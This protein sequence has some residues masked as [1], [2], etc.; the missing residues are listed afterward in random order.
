MCQGRPARRTDNGGANATTAIFLRRVRQKK[1]AIFT[2]LALAAAGGS[3]VGKRIRRWL[4]SYTVQQVILSEIIMALIVSEESQLSNLNK[5][6]ILIVDSQCNAGHCPLDLEKIEAEEKFYLYLF[7]FTIF[8][9]RYHT[10]AYRLWKFLQPA[11]HGR[12]DSPTEASNRGRRN[13]RPTT[14]RRAGALNAS[15][16]SRGG[17]VK[18]T[19]NGF[20]HATADV[21]A[22]G[23][24]SINDIENGQFRLSVS[25][26]PIINGHDRIL[27]PLTVPEHMKVGHSPSFVSETNAHDQK[28]GVYDLSILYSQLVGARGGTPTYAHTH[29]VQNI[30]PACARISCGRLFVL[31]RVPKNICVL[32]LPRQVFFEFLSRQLKKEISTVCSEKLH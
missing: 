5:N 27:A 12:G 26:S 25:F 6:A 22:R 23:P 31:N 9:F 10:E 4:A 28:Y 13:P 32:L 19:S 1:T 3:L 20:G 2:D 8:I 7:L 18:Y 29:H 21:R 14:G 15:A 17:D 24:R 11:S 16:Q 30:T